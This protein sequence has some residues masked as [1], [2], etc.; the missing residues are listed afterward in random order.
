MKRWLLTLTAALPAL[1]AAAQPHTELRPTETV[2]L[3]ASKAEA[4]KCAD[5]VIGHKRTQCEELGIAFKTDLILT[6]Q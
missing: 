4:K 1:T 3:Y 6:D 2:F 5:A